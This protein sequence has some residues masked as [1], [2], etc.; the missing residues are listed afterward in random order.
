ML[1]PLSPD[2]AVS[3]LVNTYKQSRESVGLDHASAIKLA[4]YT[5]GVDPVK[6]EVLI[7]AQTAG[8]T[9]PEEW[10]R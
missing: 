10:V 6:A 5:H 4:A 8:G 3:V 2:E 9:F 1:V 7:N